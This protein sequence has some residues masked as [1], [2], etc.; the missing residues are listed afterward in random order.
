MTIALL[1]DWRSRGKLITIL[2]IYR[3]L[4]NYTELNAPRQ[5]NLADYK[6]FK[7]T[8]SEQI[9][10][11]FM[12]NN[13]EKHGQERRTI[14]LIEQNAIELNQ[15]SM[16]LAAAFNKSNFEVQLFQTHVA[17]LPAVLEDGVFVLCTRRRKLPR[18]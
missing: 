10:L 9:R 16:N 11:T 8:H 1:L 15:N 13:S 7:R 14:V 5:F 17:T 2:R 12:A 4:F 3:V 18:T 6:A